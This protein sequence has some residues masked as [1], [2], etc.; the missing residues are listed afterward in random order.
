MAR[1]KWYGQYG[2]VQNGTHKMIRKKMVWIK[3]YR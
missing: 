3:W 2:I 1:T